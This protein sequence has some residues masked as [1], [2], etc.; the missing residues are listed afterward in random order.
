LEEKTLFLIFVRYQAGTESFLISVGLQVVGEQMQMM[1]ATLNEGSK[2]Q[3]QLCFPA[4]VV[5][6]LA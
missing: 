1:K 5:S 3:R 4:G 2:S 6:P